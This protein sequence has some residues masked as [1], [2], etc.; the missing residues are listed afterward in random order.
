MEMDKYIH[1]VRAARRELLCLLNFSSLSF[2]G[3]YSAAMLI[4]AIADSMY[5]DT[6]GQVCQYMDTARKK[7]L[8]KPKKIHQKVCKCSR[9]HL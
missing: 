5:F 1:R 6:S 4:I 7:N 8:P 2:F 3:R 9:H